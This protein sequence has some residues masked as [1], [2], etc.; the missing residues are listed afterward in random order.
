MI[1]LFE[2]RKECT[3]C[4]ACRFVCPKDAVRMEADEEGFAVPVV[5]GDKCIDCGACLRICPVRNAEAVREKEEPRFF[6]AK[7]QDPE[8][9]FHST[10]GGAFTALS[11]AVEVPSTVWI[12]VRT[13]KSVMSGRMTARAATGCGIPSMSRAGWTTKYTG[14]LEKT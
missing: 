14:R 11:D 12:S 2:D 6:V 9:L 13:S 10:S 3:G 1:K 4:G 7:H 5:D 8:V